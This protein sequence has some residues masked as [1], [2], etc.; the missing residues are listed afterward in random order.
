MTDSPHEKILELNRQIVDL[1][2]NGDYQGAVPFAEQ[3]CALSKKHLSDTHPDYGVNLNNLALI[4][5]WI[6]EYEK[7][8]D[9]YKQAQE[10][11]RASIGEEHKDY[12]ILVNNIGSLL[13]HQGRF[14]E[15]RQYY[16]EASDIA[17]A[18]AGDTSP[19]YFRATYNLA[20]SY[21]QTGDSKVAKQM[22]EALVTAMRDVYEEPN[23]DIAENLNSLANVYQSL[24]DYQ[25]A[26]KCYEEALTIYDK[27]L[28]PE[29]PNRMTLMHNFATLYRTLG[30]LTK[31][32]DIQRRVLEITESQY[33]KT[34]TDY[35]ATLLNYA[36]IETDLGRYQSAETHLQEALK[37]YEQHFGTSAEQYATALN[38]LALLQET[39]GQYQKAEANFRQVVAIREAVWGKQHLL[40]AKNIHNLAGLLRQTDRYSEAEDLYRQALNIKIDTVGEGHPSYLVT[41]EA[42]ADLLL[43]LG[44][45]GR[46]QSYYETALAYYRQLFATNNPQIAATLNELG[47]VHQAAGEYKTAIPYFQQAIKISQQI[48]GDVHPIVAK[49]KHNLAV[50]YRVIGEFDKAGL[51][52]QD[53]SDIYKATLGAGHYESVLALSNLASLK[54]AHGDYEEAI[55]LLKESYQY[56]TKI[57]GEH[58]PFAASFL[59]NFAVSYAAS[60]KT[61]EAFATVSQVQQ[62]YDRLI[63]TISA[64]GSDVRRLSYLTRINGN[65]Y[66]SLSLVQKYFRDSRQHIETAYEWVLRRKGLATDLMASNL[67][68]ILKVQT[69]K[70]RALLHEWQR[71]QQV[72]S[73]LLLGDMKGL[74]A[75]DYEQ[76][77]AGLE[78]ERDF[79][80]SEMARI[81]STDATQLNFESVSTSALQKKLAQDVALIEYIRYD[82]YNFEAIPA[83]TGEKNWQAPRYLV[84]V[85]T[86]TQ[87]DMVDIGDA[88]IIDTLV[89]HLREAIVSDR[90]SSGRF[91][92]LPADVKAENNYEESSRALHEHVFKPIKR[93]LAGCKHLYIS[94][95]GDLLQLPFELLLEDNQFLLDDFQISYL[96]IGRELLRDDKQQTSQA[97][98]VIASPDFNLGVSGTDSVEA[99]PSI[100]RKI[101]R[102]GKNQSM[103]FLPLSGTLR[104]GQSVASLL[105]VPLKSKGDAVKSVVENQP[106]PRILHIATHGYFL[107]DETIQM[108]ALP[109][110]IQIGSLPRNSMLR[111]G[112][113][114]AGANTWLSNQPTNE[115]VGNGLLTANDVALLDLSGTK[116]VVLSACDTALGEI[117][118]GEGVFGLRR[119]FMLAGAQTLVMSLW[120]VPDE[121]TAS[122]MEIFYQELKAGG[123]RIDA[124]RFAQNEIRKQHKHPYYWAAFIC[125]GDIDKLVL[126]TGRL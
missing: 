110:D 17:K 83:K 5:K 119:A 114:L 35:A 66:I 104:E 57:F 108:R 124:L 32:E 14:D 81:S 46:S 84:F 100:L 99:Q 48:F 2:D 64:T 72:L 122:L 89:H 28:P 75:E 56:V 96:A 6:G 27:V 59:F 38:N 71:V 63:R 53:A 60:N 21:E 123:S 51:Y 91:G 25:A 88:S 13:E 90:N 11:Y 24:G 36:G 98:L 113:A 18:S 118:I 76:E 97:P 86:P 74:S 103:H 26:L 55:A 79:L 93:F 87:V 47:R 49:Y 126:Q 107:D 92:T 22:L 3:A 69:D 1:I 9:V 82:Y 44:E 105:N 50:V 121:Q 65:L 85:V 19:E 8:I 94:P 15:A 40:Y 12:A 102:N 16:Q 37:I 31:A 67:R 112:L 117:Q 4:Y 42:Y 101:I 68:A 106:S 39:I 62:I 45:I 10:V 70:G 7:S 34:H 29:H 54:H 80:E 73:N 95:D 120:K 30:M 78:A 115:N 52:A 125:Q 58:L 111:S 61:D 23:R 43:R 116:L 20:S 41:L 77:I 109:D 33:G